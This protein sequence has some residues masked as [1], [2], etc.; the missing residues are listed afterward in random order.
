MNINSAKIAEYLAEFLGAFFLLVIIVL[1]GV[2]GY[3][4]VF[5]P[6]IIGFGLAV[7]IYMLGKYTKGHFNPV[8]TL[9]AMFTKNINLFDGAIY[10]L[11]QLLA[12][13]IAF[14]MLGVI[15]DDFI[16][17]SVVSS[18]LS[19][20]TAGSQEAYDQYVADYE[21]SRVPQLYNSYNEGQTPIVAFVE[22][23]FTFLF[24]MTI[25]FVSTQEK[26]KNMAGGIIGIGLTVF[27]YLGVV[28]SGA[29]YHTFRSII[30]AFYEWIF[31]D[32]SEALAQ[33]GW[34]YLLPH[35][36]AIAL[37]V[38]VF[39]LFKFFD[40]PNMIAFK[41]PSKDSTAVTDASKKEKK[42]SEKK[43]KKSK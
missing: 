29:S 19:V 2:F 34:G 30:P 33:V 31:N 42:E 10:L 6:I 5:G 22:F 14:P 39:W 26:F 21:E 18:G 13:M 25:L 28:V 32:S 24:V 17:F 8:V 15:R 40:N 16:D 36:A 20:E 9:A 4:L 7:L 23:F 27:T 37:V 43:K 1:S 38:L 11:V 35:I 3:S 12:A 41:T